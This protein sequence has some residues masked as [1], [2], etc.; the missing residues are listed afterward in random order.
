MTDAFDPLRQIRPDLLEPADPGDPAAYTRAKDQLMSQITDDSLPTEMI[1]TPD[2][3]PRLAYNDELAAVDYLS[4]V[5]GFVEARESRMEFGGQYLCW[6]RLGTGMVM[7]G[8]SDADVHQ[9]HS[10]TDAGLTTV[11][12]NVYVPDIDAHYAT[13]VAHD[14]EVTMELEDAFYGERRY[15]ATDPEGHR[16]HFAERFASIIQRDGRAPEPQPMPGQ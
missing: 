8:R 5:F 11:M 13:A 1:V 16:W 3:Y 10:P 9:I 6:L 7:V 4:R 15:E 2:L 12:L 14:A